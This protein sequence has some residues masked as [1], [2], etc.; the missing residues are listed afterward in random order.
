MDK[1][2]SCSRQSSLVLALKE[3]ERI[4]K[5]IFILDYISNEDLRRKIQK[6]LN[7]GEATNA[8]ARAIFLPNK[9]SF[10]KEIFCIRCNKQVCLIF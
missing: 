3:I 1:I 9:K 4:E 5:A 2:G 7:K 10:I 6:G 8:L